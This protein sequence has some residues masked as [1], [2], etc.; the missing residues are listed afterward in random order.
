M[1]HDFI[2][3][4]IWYFFGVIWM[5]QSCQRWVTRT[6]YKRGDGHKGVLSIVGGVKHCA[7]YDIDKLKGVPWS[8]ELLG[9]T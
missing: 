2:F 5:E 4:F 3:V 6:K 8:P 9:G 1:P 7:H